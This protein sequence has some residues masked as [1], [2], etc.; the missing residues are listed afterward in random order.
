MSVNLR[1]AIVLG[2]VAGFTLTVFGSRVLAG[3][4]NTTYTPVAEGST[5]NNQ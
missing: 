3:D 1:A 4:T 2:C 5:P